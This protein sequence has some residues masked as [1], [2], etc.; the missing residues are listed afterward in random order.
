[1]IFFAEA[2]GARFGNLIGAL[3]GALRSLGAPWTLLTA[4]EMSGVVKGGCPSSRALPAR[5]SMPGNASHRR[6]WEVPR[7]ER[8]VR[9][10]TSFYAVRVLLKSPGVGE[11]LRARTLEPL[12]LVRYKLYS[13][14]GLCQASVS[15]SGVVNGTWQPVPVSRQII[16]LRCHSA[17]AVLC[18][19]RTYQDENYT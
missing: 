11:F 13:Y 15:K 14:I 9:C 5:A 1:M 19:Y 17:T 8:E 2:E 12:T 3:W 18:E 7:H 4:A 6:M 10:T 16:I